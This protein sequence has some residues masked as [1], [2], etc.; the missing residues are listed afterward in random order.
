MRTLI[1]TPLRG[2][3]DQ[4]A[5]MLCQYGPVN[6]VEWVAA[7]LDLL[8]TE[9]PISLA[10]CTPG[11][12]TP[13][14]ARPPAV[15]PAFVVQDPAM[16]AALRQ[17]EQAAASQAAVLITGEP[18]TGKELLAAHLHRCSRRAD[19]PFV[20]LDCSAAGD[21]MFASELFGHESGTL[22]GAPTRRIGRFE[23][24]AGGSLLLD[25]V[26]ALD[27]R[28][29]ARLLRAMQQRGIDRLGA[30]APVPVDVRVIATS[31]RD[32]QQDVQRG[33][34]RAELLMLLGVVTIHVPPLRERP[35]DI[36]ALA[37]HFARSCAEAN[38]LPPAV[39]SPAAQDALLRHCWPANVRELEWVMHRAVLRQPGPCITA[40][41]LEIAA[42][43][44]AMP[45]GTLQAME[46][47]LILDTLAQCGGNRNQTAARLGISIRTLRNKLH[48]Y[49][50]SGSMRSTA[51][52]AG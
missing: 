22:P 11:Q 33:R 29:Q 7:A 47:Q 51:A 36:V 32:L 28:M 13:P 12:A 4:A 46:R 20:P 6:D 1:I 16:R 14:P 24:A 10:L 17:V 48:E 18:G 27:A 38:G 8:M 39:L 30:N 42:T 40:E 50:R 9:E 25:E 26:G 35:G 43:E 45:A 52:G 41:D 49:E 37:E 31:S 3:R 21:A 34:F 2:G 44:P 23:A 19:R 5:D 15:Q